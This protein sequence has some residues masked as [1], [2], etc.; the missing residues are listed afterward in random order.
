MMLC[1]VQSLENA[2]PTGK[3]VCKTLG[4]VAEFFGVHVQTIHGWRSEKMPGH[5][6]FWHLPSLVKWRLDKAE[7]RNGNDDMSE[8]ERELRRKERRLII[9][10]RQLDLDE[11]RGLLISKE[12][13]VSGM[14]EACAAVRLQLESLP[15]LMVM[16]EPAELRDAKLSEWREK[17][18]L[19]LK[20]L[21]AMG[22]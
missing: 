3:W 13:S 1:Q 5:E 12:D 21:E 4:D 9:E 22:Q 15:A 20:E 18:V 17:I 8:S 11:K 10:R 2:Q 6:G 7:K 19:T 16:N 14:T